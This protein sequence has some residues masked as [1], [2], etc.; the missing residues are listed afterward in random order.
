MNFA[1][2]FISIAAEETRSS[3]KITASVIGLSRRLR[4]E[5][6]DWISPSSRKMKSTNRNSDDVSPR[7]RIEIGTVTG[8]GVPRCFPPWAKAEPTRIAK[9]ITPVPAP[10]N[11]FLLISV[12]ARVIILQCHAKG[13]KPRTSRAGLRLL[14]R[15]SLMI[16]SMTEE[17][18]KDVRLDA[19][20]KLTAREKRLSQM[21]QAA[22]W[23]ALAGVAV[24]P[25][26]LLLVIYLLSGFSPLLL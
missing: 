17:I 16:A 3:W 4:F 19:P 13:K 18:S 8:F 6:S 22:P 2:F 14:T 12:A 5:T 1:M 7:T 25:P 15:V 20:G 9:A 10:C 21:W 26:A 24:I 11:S 23:L